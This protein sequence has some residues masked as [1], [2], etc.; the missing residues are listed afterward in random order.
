MEQNLVIANRLKGLCEEKNLSYNALAERSGVPV[1]RIYRIAYGNVSNP[2]VFVML[3]ICDGL[4]I[5]LDEFFGTEE[6]KELRK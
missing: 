4:E 6:F 3:R 1:K 5:S 2:S